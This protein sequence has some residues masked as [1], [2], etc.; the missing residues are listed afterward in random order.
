M[1]MRSNLSLHK[2]LPGKLVSCV[3]DLKLP[4]FFI[5]IV[6]GGVQTGSTRHVGHR[7]GRVIMM[8]ENLVE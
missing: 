6:G 8:M 1:F 7:M 3:R 2:H 4:L 5:R